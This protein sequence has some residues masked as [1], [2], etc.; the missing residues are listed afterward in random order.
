VKREMVFVLR[1]KICGIEGR[2]VLRKR[3]HYACRG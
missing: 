1:W 3:H 2:S